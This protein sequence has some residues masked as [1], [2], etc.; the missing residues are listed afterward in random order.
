MFCRFQNLGLLL[1]GF[2]AGILLGSLIHFGYFCAFLGLGCV[3][4]GGILCKLRR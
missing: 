3:I 4:L 1:L 2:G